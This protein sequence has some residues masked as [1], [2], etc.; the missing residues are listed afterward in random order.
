MSK[1]GNPGSRRA[2]LVLTVGPLW[3]TF[4]FFQEEKACS[5]LEQASLLRKAG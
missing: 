2:E 1:R 5:I 3:T 4:T